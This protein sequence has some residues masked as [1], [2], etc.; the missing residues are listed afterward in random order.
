MIAAADESY[1][2][3]CVTFSPPTGGLAQGADAGAEVSHAA[4]APGQHTG[5]L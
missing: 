5:G 4:E 1:C 2:C 3:F